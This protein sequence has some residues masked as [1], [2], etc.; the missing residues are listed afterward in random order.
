[1]T[2]KTEYVIIIVE[3]IIDN[4]EVGKMK[5]YK[6]Y[7]IDGVIFNNE[8]EIDKYLE[9]KIMELFINACRMFINNPCMETSV[10]CSELSV[11]LADKYGYTMDELED[12]EMEVLIK[13]REV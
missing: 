6:G 1:M 12:I 3:D 4:R 11:K 10:R 7:Y 5:R 13:I 9:E 2:L 8:A